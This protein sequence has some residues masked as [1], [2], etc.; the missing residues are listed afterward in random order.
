MGE[1]EAGLG[2]SRAAKALTHV[3]N[4][5]VH[6]LSLRQP[7]RPKETD[8]RGSY[9]EMKPEDQSRGHVTA[10][11]L[12]KTK[13]PLEPHLDHSIHGRRAAC[14]NG[15]LRVWQRGC[16]AHLFPSPSS[17]WDSLSRSENLLYLSVLNFSPTEN[18]SHL[19][20]KL[21]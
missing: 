12:H 1:T 20:K 21:K 7:G 4:L 18:P 2:A 8:L 6:R 11:G 9:P 17:L 14:S 5:K 10:K 13:S 16:H 19:F 3:G 15:S